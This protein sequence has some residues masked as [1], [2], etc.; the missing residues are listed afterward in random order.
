VLVAGSRRA[1]FPTDIERSSCVSRPTRPQLDCK[2]LDAQA[3]RS[4]LQRRLSDEVA[5]RTSQLTAVNEELRRS[6]ATCRSAKA[7]SDGEFRLEALHR[8]D[9]LV[10]GNLS[11][12]PI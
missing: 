2:R 8:R 7:Q 6:Q 11:N 12:L 10:R 9:P 3:T 5:E 1:D 4:V